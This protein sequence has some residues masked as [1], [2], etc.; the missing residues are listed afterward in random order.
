MFNRKND[1]LVVFLFSTS[2][3]KSFSLLDE[4]LFFHT[5]KFSSIAYRCEFHRV[6]AVSLLWSGISYVRLI[7]LIWDL[8]RLLYF[9]HIRLMAQI[10]CIYYLCSLN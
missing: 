4:W 1:L 10:V 7:G 6:A 5:I 9:T 2:C 3:S 8:V